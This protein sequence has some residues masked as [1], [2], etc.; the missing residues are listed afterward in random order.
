MR[1]IK[2]YKIV[3]M[4][5]VPVLI[6]VLFR[7][8]GTI[9]FQSDSKRWAEPSVMRSNIITKELLVSLPGERLLI[10][11][12]KEVFADNKITGNTLNISPDSILIK[13]KLDAIRKHNGPLLLCSSETAVSARIWMLLSQMGVRTIYILTNDSDNEVFKNKFKPDTLV[14]PKL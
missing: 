4:V 2:K 12:D 13:N 7:S 10:N 1:I 8:F 14:G 11:L 6:L 5:V 9:H 3:I